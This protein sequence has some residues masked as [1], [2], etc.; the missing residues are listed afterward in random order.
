MKINHPPELPPASLCAGHPSADK[1]L[2]EETARERRKPPLFIPDLP[3]YHHAEDYDYS[4]ACAG[5]VMRSCS[6]IVSFQGDMNQE[7]PL[8]MFS[9]ISKSIVHLYADPGTGCETS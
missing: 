8:E 9:L 5:V 3:P 4:S 1:L 7:T 6:C 2:I